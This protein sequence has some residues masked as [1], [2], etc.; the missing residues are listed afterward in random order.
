MRCLQALIAMGLVFG[1]A[2]GGSAADKAKKKNKKG[3]TPVVGV[4]H[5]VRTAFDAYRGLIS[6]EASL[7][8]H[9]G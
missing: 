3:A 8:H 6:R 7:E 4:V 5:E 2:A 9:P 1:L